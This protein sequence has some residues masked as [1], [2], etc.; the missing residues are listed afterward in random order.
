[1]IVN[2]GKERITPHKTFTEVDYKYMAED[3]TVRYVG[4]RQ[5]S[6]SCYARYKREVEDNVKSD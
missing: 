4:F 3:K 2:T 5:Y 6:E 1:M